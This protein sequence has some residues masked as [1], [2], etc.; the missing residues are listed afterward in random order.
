MTFTISTRGVREVGV[1]N[2]QYQN[3]MELAKK[4][5]AEFDSQTSSTSQSSTASQPKPIPVSKPPPSSS[6]GMQE[7]P[8]CQKGVPIADLPAH[9]EQHL[10]D[11]EGK[12]A[13]GSK[14]GQPATAK[15][16]EK[17]LFSKLFGKNEDEKKPYGSLLLHFY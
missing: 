10:E 8:M 7:C 6:S 15:K 12:R 14:P 4:L 11:D 2:D 9:V 16:E 13:A 17:G 5:Q 3:D 1:S